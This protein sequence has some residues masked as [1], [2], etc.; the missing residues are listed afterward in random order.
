MNS[1][2]NFQILLGKRMFLL[3]RYNQASELFCVQGMFD[4][5]FGHHGEF[6]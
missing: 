4:V 3:K 2:Y 1:S 5:R 6:G